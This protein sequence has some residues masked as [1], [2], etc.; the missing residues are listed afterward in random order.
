[1]T[2]TGTIPLRH[3]GHCGIREACHRP[4]CRL[5]FGPYLTVEVRDDGERIHYC[6]RT[7]WRPRLEDTRFLDRRRSAA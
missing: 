6:H 5:A 7:K 1:M 3:D 4:E 2:G